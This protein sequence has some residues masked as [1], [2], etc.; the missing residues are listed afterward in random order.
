LGEIKEEATIEEIL[1]VMERF[2]QV[3]KQITELKDFEA[4]EIDRAN[5]RGDANRQIRLVNE[6]LGRQKLLLDEASAKV[7]AYERLWMYA[8]GTITGYM[9]SLYEVGS[10]MFLGLEDAITQFAITG[11]LRFR[12]FANSVI[13]DLIRIA[14]RAQVVAPLA[15]G[16]LG[17]FGGISWG[18]AATSSV[19]LGGGG[20]GFTG[21]PA[22]YFPARAG[23]GEVYPGI[24]YL[25]GE[26]GKELF[27]PKVPG[28]VTPVERAGG[29]DVKV[30]IINESGSPMQVTKS[31]AR[32]DPQELIVTLWLDAVEHNKYGLAYAL[33]RA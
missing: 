20:Y 17:L 29:K 9:A 12:D 31:T 21:L 14:V 33:G 11:K 4:A 13:A 24:T 5:L 27:T 2:A 32:I 8:H 18:G 25:V 22:T 26:R 7:A 6:G 19:S 16:L 30:Q 23:G 1:A 3:Q 15:Q 10:R 28:V